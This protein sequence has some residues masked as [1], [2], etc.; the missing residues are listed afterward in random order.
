MLENGMQRKR[1]GERNYGL[2]S[3]QWRKRVERGRKERRIKK[4]QSGKESVRV[5]WILTHF[6]TRSLIFLLKTIYSLKCCAMLCLVARLCPT[7]W[8]PMDSCLPGSSVH[9]DSLGK[10]TGVGNLSLLQGIFVT[11]ELNQ[12]LLHCR[13][14]LYQ[15]SYQG[16]WH[17]ANLNNRN[18]KHPFK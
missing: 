3:E 6:C 5:L 13:R 7:L 11:Q 9:G 10:N 2:R 15:W 4:D 14:I 18:E 1:Q 8:D 12:G 16:S 17:T